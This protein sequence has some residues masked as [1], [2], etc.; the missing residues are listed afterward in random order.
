MAACSKYVPRFK[1]ALEYRGLSFPQEIIN[2]MGKR[3]KS[4]RELDSIINSVC[5]ILE[6]PSCKKSHCPHH[7]SF[8]FCGCSLALVPG[9]CKLNI[10]YL[11]RKKEREDKLIS[12]RILQLPKKFR[13]VDDKTKDKILS[14]SKSDWEN[15]IKK[16]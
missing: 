6:P 14:M 7:T 16:F 12:E 2:V 15:Q 5:E 13:N 8:G 4:D 1:K 3:A 11:K 10:D 9:K